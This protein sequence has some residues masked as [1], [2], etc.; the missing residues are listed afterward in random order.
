MNLLVICD[1]DGT[2]SD[3]GWRHA[4]AGKEPS[5]K[6]WKQ[7]RQWLRRV[8]SK[9]MLIQ[10]KTVPGM[11]E[12][13]Q[14]LRHHCVYIT[15]RQIRYKDVTKRWLKKNGFPDLK[16]YMRSNKSKVSAGQY[17]E[18]LI[19]SLLHKSKK[20]VHTIVIDDDVRCELE[21]ICKKNNWTLL[22]A[23]NYN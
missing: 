18:N 15:A 23:M 17:K 22:K 4:I 6:N 1:I 16:L 13:V 14:L 12:M 11:R 20:F 5:R 7:Y 21:L 2:I 3:A 9:K 10:D 19:L 8:Q